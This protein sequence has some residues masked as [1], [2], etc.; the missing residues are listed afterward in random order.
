MKNSTGAVE[1]LSK[2]VQQF[3]IRVQIFVIGQFRTS[4]LDPK[5][6]K[7]KLSEGIVD[8]GAVKKEV[9]AIH[10][11]TQGAQPGDPALAAERIVDMGRLE[12]VPLAGQLPLRI[13]IGSDS[14]EIMRRKCESM[15]A[16]LD[17]WSDFASST[18]FADKICLPGYYR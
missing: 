2:E 6:K 16:L 14:L 18:D 13:P 15:L 4:I 10:A 5:N 1:S 17:A 9:A 3:N 7:S 8:Y 11:A 12:K